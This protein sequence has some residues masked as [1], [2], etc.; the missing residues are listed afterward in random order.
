MYLLPEGCKRVVNQN[1]GRSGGGIK[2]TSL[3][4][5]WLRR[6][7][8]AGMIFAC[9]AMGNPVVGSKPKPSRTGTP[10][11]VRVV[12]GLKISPA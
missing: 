9:P 8:L 6:G 5:I 4:A 11:T 12:A 2:G 1:P 10:L 7:S 3:A